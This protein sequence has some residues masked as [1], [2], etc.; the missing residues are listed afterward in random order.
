MIDLVARYDAALI[1]ARTAGQMAL[2]M[3]KDPASL[4]IEM[5][6]PQDFVTAADRAVEGYVAQALKAAFP[7]DGFL[8]EETA[9]L[10]HLV[11]ADVLW[12]VDPIDGTSNFATGRPDWCVSIG[13]MVAGVPEIG[14]IYQATLD[15]LCTAR[16]GHGAWLNGTRLRV[17]DRSIATATIGLDH[18]QNASLALHVQQISAILASGGEYRRN[19]SAAVSLSQVAQGTLDGFSEMFL[20][21]WDVMAGIVLVTE[22]GG[23]CSPFL[24][25]GGLE[26]GAGFIACSPAVHDLMLSLPGWNQ[27]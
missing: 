12:V 18:S 11:R 23:W 10:D 16:R 7:S 8:G 26:K 24:D 1:V 22:A 21:P 25:S 14:V 2:A 15:T 3:L 9:D 17:A 4:G 5:K 19:G 6:G 13:L 20:W 27:R